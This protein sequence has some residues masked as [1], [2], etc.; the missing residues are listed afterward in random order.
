MKVLIITDLE[1]VSGVVDWDTDAK[2]SPVN[3]Y[4]R[5]L[6]T[7]E[8]NAAV[9]AAFDAG[10]TRVKVA[11]GHDAIDFLHLDERATLVPGRYP[12]TPVLQGW[13]EGF[14][15]L[16][17]IGHHSMAGTADGVLAHSYNQTVRLMT[18][19]NQPIGEIGMEAAEAGDFGIP[20]VMV[21]GDAA[22][23]REARELLGDIETAAV[24]TGYDTHHA[25]CLHPG[26]ARALIR[27]K[28]TAGL[29][30]L[31][32][33]R[34]FVV[35]GPIEVATHAYEPFTDKVYAHYAHKPWVTFPDNKTCVI[36]ADNVV[37]AMARRCGLDYTWTPPHGD[38]KRAAKREPK[39]SS[40]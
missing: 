36:R 14:E 7:G 23:C 18:L 4:H 9:A 35:P 3:Q 1:G 27:E 2:G 34:P 33:F 16:I 29:E 32:D 5:E 12:A 15:A 6:M 37:E 19:N 40:E 28:V 13:E 38:S 22:A 11:E 10:A 21:S 26:R 24:K 17:M 39:R 8:L 20:V 25:E 31:Q 30:R